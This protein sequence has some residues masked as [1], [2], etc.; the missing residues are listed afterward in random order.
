MIS[1]SPG[2]LAPRSR[3]GW[4]GWTVKALFRPL[5]E[6]ST[7]MRHRREIAALLRA[8]ASVLRDLGLM[9]SDVDSA[10]AQPMWRDPSYILLASSAERRC[11]NREAAREN[12]AGL[13]H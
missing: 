7:A 5:A 8:D 12:L 2:T 11:A 9:P 4:I 1:I 13:G 3:D 10:L 6:V